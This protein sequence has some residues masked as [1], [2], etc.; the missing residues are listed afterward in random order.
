MDQVPPLVRI[1]VVQLTG[2]YE[3]FVVD[4]SSDERRSGS[5]AS[6]SRDAI[7][8]DQSEINDTIEALER[9]GDEVDLELFEDADRCLAHV[10][11]GAVDLVVLDSPLDGAALDLL[12][13]LGTGGPPAIV[14]IREEGNDAA[15]EAFRRGAADCVRVGADYSQ[16]LPEM[17]LEQMQRW[18]EAVERRSAERRIRW[19][20][21]LHDA[22]VSEIPAALVVLDAD[23]RV[24]TSNP[25]CSRLF[26]IEAREAEGRSYESV[27]P[28]DVIE[29]AGVAR[30]LADA[31]EGRNG[32]PRMR[33]RPRYRPRAMR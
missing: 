2:K 24:V 23:S 5:S 1:A 3:P 6:S 30:L 15:L 33:Q 14:V 4:P 29:S 28:A 31:A 32:A 18:R 25:E 27:F 21:R 10:Q 26:G 7:D 22:I 16:V 9:L 13:A 20:E 19:L 11:A 8:A 12:D 17:A